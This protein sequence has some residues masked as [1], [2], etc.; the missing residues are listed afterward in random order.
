MVDLKKYWFEAMLAV[1]ASFGVIG[2]VFWINLTAITFWWHMNWWWIVGIIALATGRW[3]A[4]PLWRAY[5]AISDHVDMR[6][7]RAQH[8]MMLAGV[9][10]KMKDGF[11]TEY[12]NQPLGLQLKV[13]NPYTKA[14][15]VKIQEV[16]TQQQQIEGPR[17]P[18]PRDFAEILGAFAPNENSIYLLDTVKGP[19]TVPMNGLCHV[20]LGGVTGGGKTNTTRL[21]TAQILACEGQVYMANPNFAPVKLNGKRLE[22]WRPIANRLKEPPAREIDEIKD[23]FGRF[24]QLFEQRRAD[25]QKSPR[26]GKDVYLVVGELPAIVAR[27]KEATQIL[28]ML[29]R[30]SRQ[31]GIHVI[32]EFQDALLS[33]IGGNSGVRKQYRTAF[34]FG[35]DPNTAKIL[36]DLPNGVK[37]DETGLGEKGAAYLRSH[38]NAYCPGRVPFFSN[39]ALYMLLGT[40]EDPVG[41]DLVMSMEELPD[42]FM[43]FV[44]SN[45][46]TLSTQPLRQD[47][48]NFQRHFYTRDDNPYDELLSSIDDEE[49]S[50]D[51]A[52]ENAIN[53]LVDGAQGTQ[54]LRYVLDS[55]KV[56][57][58][59]IAYKITGNIDE[60]LKQIGVHTGYRAHARKIIAER[61]LR[62][63]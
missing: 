50:E 2:V 45:P 59:T 42:E 34:H 28:G 11:D 63:V 43:P 48:S 61:G 8:Y 23:L 53:E 40:P 10:A 25:E 9:N 49:K 36:L 13:H 52:Q 24:M 31:Y 39:R 27:W 3:W 7:I 37:I 54:E 32:S 56:E 58:F 20:A 19:I 60:S 29:L 47:E 21:L 26:R 46:V 33:T 14:S 44:D 5:L 15:Q 18:H 4:T 41:D 38:S 6:K 22:D 30:E 62:K 55:V 57:L 16:P 12:H 51:Y 35:G 17:F 1:A